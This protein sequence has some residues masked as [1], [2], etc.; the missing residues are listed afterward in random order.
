[1]AHL[2]EQ[3]TTRERVVTIDGEII[4][5]TISHKGKH[6]VTKRVT[7]DKF[8][9]TYVEDIADIYKIKSRPQVNLLLVLCEE[10]KFPE[11]ENE[12]STFTALKDD[13]DR[14]ADKLDIKRGKTIDNALAGLRQKNI[15]IQIARSRYAVNPKYL[16]Y[17]ALK[18]RD[19]LMEL[20]IKYQ[21]K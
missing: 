15:I 9:Q 12:L 18:D 7:P 14:W 10:A 21:V 6:I 17:G 19:S 4:S 1:M 16:H 2:Q 8:V 20:I 3:E 13:K 5:D 11:G